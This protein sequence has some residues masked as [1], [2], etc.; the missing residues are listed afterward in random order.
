MSETRI[1]ETRLEQFK[2]TLFSLR[3]ELQ[4]LEASSKEAT[5]SV[6][7]DQAASDRFS[8][9]DAMQAQLAAGVLVHAFSKKTQQ[10]KEKDIQLSEKRME[11]WILRFPAGGGV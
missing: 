6:E 4:D 10:L 2:H 9:R 8:R 1:N 3:A 11:D 5:Q 7:P